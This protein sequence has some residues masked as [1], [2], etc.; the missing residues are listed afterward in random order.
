M[1]ASHAEDAGVVADQ[2]RTQWL[3]ANGFRVVRYWNLDVLRNTIGVLDDLKVV[4]QQQGH[5]MGED[6]DR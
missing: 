3:E 4:L 1:A 6:D 2:Q 5:D